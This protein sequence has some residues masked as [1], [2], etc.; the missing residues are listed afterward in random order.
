MAKSKQEWKLVT[1]YPITEYQCGA[2][3]GDRVRLRRELAIRDH[4]DKLTGN[5]YPTGEIWIVLAGA[6][7][8]P[9]VIW[10]RQPNGESHTW[11]DT[12]DFWTWFEKAPP[13]GDP[14]A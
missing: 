8:E 12:D 2:K 6:N 11:D 9:I 5:S 7:E 14:T 3:V 1:E 4:Q 13:G 10:L